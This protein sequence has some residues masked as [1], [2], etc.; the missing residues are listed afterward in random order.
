MVARLEIKLAAKEPLSNQMASVFQ[1]VLMELLP[2]KYAAYLH[3][4]SLHPYSQHLE[5]K[6]KCWY[7]VINCLNQ[8][9]TEI[10]LM[11]VLMKKN[12]IMLKKQKLEVKF[13][14][15]RYS[16]LGD[17][18]LLH[19]FYNEEKSRYLNLHFITPTAFKQA[20]KYLFYPDLRCMYQSCMNKYDAVMKDDL[21]KTSIKMAKP[22]GVK[23]VIKSMD[24]AVKAIN[25]GV[26]DKYK[27]LTVVESIK[28]A[29]RLCKECNSKK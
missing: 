28:D 20:G 29:E 27:L 18:E 1:G 19:N 5:M 6:D 8:E 22:S 14:E 9:A 11:N 21:R 3:E 16:E 7:W 15:K 12:S 10:I 13:T 2:E 25:S 4:S 23:L 26:T 24:D 17:K